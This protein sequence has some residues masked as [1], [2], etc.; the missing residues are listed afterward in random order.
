MD[1][2]EQIY[3]SWG[4]KD[5][6]IK[7]LDKEELLRIGKV[8]NYW[9]KLVDGSQNLIEDEWMTDGSQNG[10]GFPILVHLRGFN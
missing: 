1:F 6:E 8:I 2:I 4:H 10:V 5:H 3:K 7:M 9:R